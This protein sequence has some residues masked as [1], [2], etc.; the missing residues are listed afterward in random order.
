M[1]RKII[2]IGLILALMLSVMALPVSAEGQGTTIEINGG[3]PVKVEPNGTIN[4]VPIGVKTLQVSEGGK[5]L[6]GFEFTLHWNPDVMQLNGLVSSDA[7][8]DRGFALTVGG[9]DQTT[10]SVTVAALST[11]Y[12]IDDL[13]I[14]LLD[15]TAIGGTNTSGDITITVSN[16]LDDT[17][18]SIPC[19]V[20]GTTLTITGVR[21]DAS[22]D[23]KVDIFDAMFIAQYIV[24][25]R[26]AED[27]NIVDAASACPD[28]GG[29]VLN[30]FDAM[31]IVQR[32]VG[33]RDA[34]WNMV[35]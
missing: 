32:I 6:A 9:I 15:I 24:G 22:G 4:L 21:G 25:Q 2:T 20:V 11:N 1:K 30:I 33:Q 35:D 3:E 19:A 16:L 18:A 5:G 31:F 27:I 7:L 23:G 13:V 12:S 28:E 8:Q 26:A 14:A 29:N 10:G 34:D 17:L